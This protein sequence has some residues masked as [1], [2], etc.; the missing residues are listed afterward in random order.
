VF[1]PQDFIFLTWLLIIAA[2]ALFFFTGDTQ[3]ITVSY[4]YEMVA[5]GPALVPVPKLVSFLASLV[6][7][8]AVLAGAMLDVALLT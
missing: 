5:L 7:L 3:T 4:S 2:L 6:Q 8:G 1:W